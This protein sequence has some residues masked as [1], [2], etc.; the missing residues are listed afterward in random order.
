MILISGVMM[1]LTGT[2]TSLVWPLSCCG[3]QMELSLTCVHKMT[4]EHL[5]LCLHDPNLATQAVNNLL[6]LFRHMFSCK[7]TY[8]QT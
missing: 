4:H 1:F 8:L 3:M 7:N 5:H 2:G 6:L